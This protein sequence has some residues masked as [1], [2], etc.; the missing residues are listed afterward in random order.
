[1]IASNPQGM[2]A[3][4]NH[5]A[6]DRAPGAGRWVGGLFLSV[7]GVLI[8]LA[9]A[10]AATAAAVVGVIAATAFVALRLASSRSRLRSGPLLLEGRR[11]ADGWVV[12]SAATRTP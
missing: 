8:G 10:V 4:L 11:T 9:V 3:D 2:K 6:P 1:M 7:F 5:A 12:E